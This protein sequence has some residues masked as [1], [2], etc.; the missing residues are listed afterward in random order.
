ML[1][2]FRKFKLIGLCIKAH[3]FYMVYIIT[4]LDK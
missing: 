4:N 1:F 2:L 3:S